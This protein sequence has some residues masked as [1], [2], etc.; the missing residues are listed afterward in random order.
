MQNAV[1]PTCSTTTSCCTCM[2]YSTRTTSSTTLR[3]QRQDKIQGLSR[4]TLGTSGN[5]HGRT[6]DLEVMP[7]FI[8]RH[9]KEGEHNERP[10]RQSSS[11]Y[12]GL[13]HRAGNM[14]NVLCEE[15]LIHQEYFK[16]LIMT[17]ILGFVHEHGRRASMTHFASFQTHFESQGS[18][19]HPGKQL[20]V[21]PVGLVQAF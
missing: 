19:H 8:F 15:N 17:F 18:S 16:K 11:R 14:L 4:Y 20:F 13:L 12:H 3:I 9:S 21:K 2:V 6:N 1:P 5:Q 7:C 10:S